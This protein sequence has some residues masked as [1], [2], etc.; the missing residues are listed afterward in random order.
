MAIL[1]P[2]RLMRVPKATPS[3]AMR[4]G[5]G[6][7]CEVMVGECGV[8]GGGGGVGWSGLVVGGV[9]VG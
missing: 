2:I 5:G 8:G 7:G 9:L 1:R 3:H 4:V 6:V